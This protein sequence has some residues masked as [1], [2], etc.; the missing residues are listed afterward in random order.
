MHAQ[1]RLTFNPTCR[2]ISYNHHDHGLRHSC[3]SVRILRI[4]RLEKIS[5][6]LTNFIKDMNVWNNCGLRPD[7]SSTSHKLVNFHIIIGV[8]R[9]LNSTT[10]M[11]YS[12]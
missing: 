10:Q 6:I 1:N 7:M 11:H 5:R 4:K 8:S 12:G 3:C 2:Q 9:N